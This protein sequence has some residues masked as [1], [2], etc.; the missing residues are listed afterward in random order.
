MTNEEIKAL[1]DV[2]QNLHSCT[3]I[4]IGSAPVHEK[5]RGQ[6]VWNGHVEIFRLSGHPKA[7][8]CYAWSH[9]CEELR[10]FVAVLA[11]PPIDSPKKAVQASIV[12]ATKKIN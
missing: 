3:A 12:G 1:R 2:V 8:T 10:Q 6:T 4:H 9:M 5:H 11:L 7:Q